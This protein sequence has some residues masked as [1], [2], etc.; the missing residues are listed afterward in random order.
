M[1]SEKSV[2]MNKDIKSSFVFIVDEN[3]KLINISLNDALF[4]AR[5]IGM[6][7]IEVG[8]K[9]NVSICRMMDF[10]KWKYEQE[11]KKKKNVQ[12]KQQTKEI[13]F[14]PNTGDND[15][16]YRAKHTD[17]FLA[18]G[19]RVKLTITFKGREQGHML[20]TGKSLLEKFLQMISA[21]YTIYSNAS[22]SGNTINMIL[23]PG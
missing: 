22:T 11:K 7:L 12:I 20:S 16:K 19:H 8:K 2:I 9:D 18:E 3:N 21:K 17:E 23:S 14:R 15:L 4:K 1:V 6:D 10:G 5:S 13:N